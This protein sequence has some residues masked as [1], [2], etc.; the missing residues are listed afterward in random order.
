LFSDHHVPSTNRYTTSATLM[1][2]DNIWVENQ[3]L[4]AQMWMQQGADGK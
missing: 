3:A 4:D 1:Y 2:P